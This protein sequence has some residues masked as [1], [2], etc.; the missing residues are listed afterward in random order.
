MGSVWL[1]GPTID[2]ISSPEFGHLVG[3]VQSA[4]EVE[5]IEIKKSINIGNLTNSFR[6]VSDF[7]K[8][9]NDRYAE[10]EVMIEKLEVVHS[11]L[12]AAEPITKD[13]ILPLV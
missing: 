6:L 11:L 4:T 2:R 13:E 10:S 1:S 9:C 8:Y 12:K 3:S 5:S 7:E